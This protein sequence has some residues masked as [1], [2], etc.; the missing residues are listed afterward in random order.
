[1]HGD[2]DSFPNDPEVRSEVAITELGNEYEKLQAAPSIVEEGRSADTRETEELELERIYK[3]WRSTFTEVHSAYSASGKHNP[4]WGDF[5]FEGKMDVTRQAGRQLLLSGHII[6]IGKPESD[7]KF[8]DTATRRIAS[9]GK[10]FG[11]EGG[12][13]VYDAIPTS[14]A[15][16]SL[17]SSSDSLMQMYIGNQNNFM[18]EVLGLKTIMKDN[19]SRTSQ[20]VPSSSGIVATNPNNVV[21]LSTMQEKIRDLAEVIEMQKVPNLENDIAEILS[22]QRKELKECIRS[23]KKK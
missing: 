21:A 3:N 9:E 18:S 20:G 8:L 1:M 14:S 5:L 16:K 17:R 22:E 15:P 19:M 10:T 6:R 13:G 11:W 7:T 12:M 4:D 2:G 23:L